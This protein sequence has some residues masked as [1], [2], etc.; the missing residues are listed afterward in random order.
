M[1]VEYG[2]KTIYGAS[3][4]IMMLETQFPRIYGDIANAAT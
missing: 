3:I 1:S 4:G 2:G